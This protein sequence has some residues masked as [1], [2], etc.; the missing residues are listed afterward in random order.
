VYLPYKFRL[1][2]GKWDKFNKFYRRINLMALLFSNLGSRNKTTYLHFR[3]LEIFRVLLYKVWSEKVFIT[4]KHR[5]D[6]WKCQANEWVLRPNLK[7]H[8]LGFFVKIPT[9]YC[10]EANSALQFNLSSYTSESFLT[11]WHC[12]SPGEMRPPNVQNPTTNPKHWPTWIWTEAP[13]MAVM[14]STVSTHNF[15]IKF[16][17]QNLNKNPYITLLWTPPCSPVYILS[18]VEIIWLSL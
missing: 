6:F 4:T 2:M 15:P 9:E 3:N 7:S 12:F 17:I 18:P 11:F 5:R 16:K 8:H 14:V 10:S 13:S 1:R